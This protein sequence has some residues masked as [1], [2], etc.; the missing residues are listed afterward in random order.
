MQQTLL[1]PVMH[2]ARA[3]PSRALPARWLADLSDLLAFPSVS[4]QPWHRGDIDAAAHWLAGHLHRIGLRN[5]AVLPGPNGGAPSV[6]GDWLLAPGQP[7]LLLYG[8]YDVQPAAPADGWRTPPFRATVVGQNLYARGASDD[9]GQLFIHLKAVE[10]L[11]A[12]AGRLPVNVKVWLE[13]EEEIGSPNLAALLDREGE[14]LRAD[15]VLVSDTEMAAPGRP[16]IVVGLRGNLSCALDVRAPGAELHS[17]RYGG[18]APDPLRV[19][20]E[21]IAGLHDR[22]GRVAVAGFY[23]RVRTFSA[24]ERRR[25][26]AAGAADARFLSDLRVPADW[27]E[28]GYSPAERIAFRPALTVNG[29][30][31]GYTGPGGKAVI[32]SRALARLGIRLVPDQEPA[33]I[34]RLLGRHI[35]AA[36]PPTVRA[37]LR[38]TAQASP[39]VSP[40]GHPLMTAAVRAVRRVWGVP[41]VFTRSGGTIPAV[42]QFQRRLG[43]PALLL[44]FGLRDDA[45]HAPNE[46]LSLP[47]FCRGVATVRRLLVECAR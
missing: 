47:N 2:T 13:G 36:T 35:A 45:I 43:A 29:V 27:G 7:T 23:D 5:V 11:L 38:F 46:K 12:H 22:Q 20:C 40:R 25:M 18:A 32:A 15:A 19:L 14:R 39:V 33:E 21:L 44:G 31:G 24:D 41:P 1:P 8:H 17:G 42:A 28:A 16:A 3:S 34:A 10:S 9:K 26:Q 6:Y 4:A 30:S 37:R